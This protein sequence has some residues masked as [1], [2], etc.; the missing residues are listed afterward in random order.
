MTGVDNANALLATVMSKLLKEEGFALGDDFLNISA[1]V[2]LNSDER[3][4]V[5]GVVQ[6]NSRRGRYRPVDL[7]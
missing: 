1:Y 5:E 7:R 6:R 4:A 2:R 3:V